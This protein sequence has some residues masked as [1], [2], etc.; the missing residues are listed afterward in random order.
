MVLP[1]LLPGDAWLGWKEHTHKLPGVGDPP[2]RA[3]PESEG[4]FLL[5]IL[6]RLRAGFYSAESGA[7]AQGAWLDRMGSCAMPSG[8]PPPPCP[9]RRLSPANTEKCNNDH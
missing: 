9:A 2:R 5:R 8:L 7:R 6:V 4:Q 3:H 1:D